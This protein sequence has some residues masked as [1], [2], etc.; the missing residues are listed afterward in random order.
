M[1]QDLNDITLNIINHYENAKVT[2]MQ[3]ANAY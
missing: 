2:L 3:T 1:A